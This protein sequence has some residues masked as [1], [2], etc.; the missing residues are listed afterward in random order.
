MVCLSAKANGTLRGI[1]DNDNR[2]VVA[3][4]WTVDCVLGT[5]GGLR[6]EGER[7][8]E[9]L[10]PPSVALRSIHPPLAVFYPFSLGIA[11]IFKT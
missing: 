9:Q 1:L 3:G 5:Y 10:M 11:I 4:Q 6:L 8:G 7:G 2:C